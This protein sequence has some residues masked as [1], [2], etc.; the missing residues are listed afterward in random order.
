M[1]VAVI[2]VVGVVAGT[3]TAAKASL[4]KNSVGAK[5]LKA[6]SVTTGKVANNAINAPRSP[7]GR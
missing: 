6:K 4:E 3:A 1:V 2:A 7:T 5:Q